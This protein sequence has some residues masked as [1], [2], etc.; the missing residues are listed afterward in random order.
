MPIQDIGL[1]EMMDGL[2]AEGAGVGGLALTLS[3]PTDYAAYVQDALGYFV[4]DDEH[5]LETVTA[6][7]RQLVESGQ[8]LTRAT[9]RL[10]LDKA[11]FDEVAYLRSLT[12][13]DGA[14]RHPGNWRDRTGQLASG[15]AHEVTDA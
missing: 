14:E 10:A 5:L 8:P 11:G 12:T 2:R 7:L 6:S 9:L 1:G 13:A 15:Y 4:I 3:N